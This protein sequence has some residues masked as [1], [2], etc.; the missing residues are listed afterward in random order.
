VLGLVVAVAALL[1]LRLWIR[2]ASAC[3]CGECFVPCIC[4]IPGPGGWVENADPHSRATRPYAPSLRAQ[5]WDFQACCADTAV[6]PS[7][8]RVTLRQR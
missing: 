3:G 7:P 4:R 6:S 5:V 2:V 8:G 1:R